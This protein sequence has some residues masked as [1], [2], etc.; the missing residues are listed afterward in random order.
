MIF[1]SDRRQ[2]EQTLENTIPG[3]LSKVYYYRIG[4]SLH[5]HIIF[6]VVDREGEIRDITLPLAK[7]LG[8]KLTKRGAGIVTTGGGAEE[9]VTALGRRL[10]GNGSLRA[11]RL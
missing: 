6:L 4:G 7:F 3:P 10:Y 2:L 1:N 8:L 9:L 11:R 5:P